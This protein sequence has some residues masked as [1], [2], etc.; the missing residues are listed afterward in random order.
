[1][2]QGI[3]ASTVFLEERPGLDV[4]TKELLAFVFPAIGPG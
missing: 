4:Y 3:T 1:M 2:L